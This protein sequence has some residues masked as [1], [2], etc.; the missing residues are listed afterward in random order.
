ML[1]DASVGKTSVLNQF[2]NREFSANY[3]PTIGSDFTSRQVEINDEFVTLQ[4]WDTAGQERF[5]ALGPTFYRGADCCI[6][7]Y[8]VTRMDT[9]RNLNL[10]HA[11]FLEQI[12]SDSRDYVAFLVLGNKIDLIDREV[13]PSMGRQWA[14]QHGYLFF[15]TSAKT[16]D[17]IMTAFDQVVIQS[18]ERERGEPVMEPISIP[19]NDSASTKTSCC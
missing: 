5:K 3:K 10:W 11:S 18:R 12:D 6:L 14:E 7:V 19:S 16:A 9:F 17:N 4:I 13:E 8:D 1:G 2:V 15:E